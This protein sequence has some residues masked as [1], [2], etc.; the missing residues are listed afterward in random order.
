MK[1]LFF[2]VFLVKSLSQ[3]KYNHLRLTRLAKFIE[4]NFWDIKLKIIENRS[5]TIFKKLFKKIYI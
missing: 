4:E 1:P 3:M 2:A 5:L